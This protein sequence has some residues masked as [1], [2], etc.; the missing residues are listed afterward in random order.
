[1]SGMSKEQIRKQSEAAYGQWADQWR[2]QAKEHYKE[3]HLRME[4]FHNIGVGKACVV[5][6][7][8]QS[9]EENID[10]LREHQE[11]V[12]IMVCDKALGHLIDNGIT[13][14]YVLVCDANVSY[15]K[16]MRPWEDKL[17]DTILFINVCGNPKWTRGN[18]FK[19]TYFFVNED[20]L[21]SEIEF[22]K[23]SNCKNVIPAATNV[24]NAMCVLLTQCSNRGRNNFFGYDKYLLLGYDYCWSN[25]KNYYAFDHDGGG[26]RW[27]MRHNIVVDKAGKIVSTSNNLLFSSKW[28]HHYLALFKLLF[29]NCSDT[30]ILPCISMGKLEDHITYKYKTD[31]MPAV[32]KLIKELNNIEMLKKNLVDKITKISTDHYKEVSAT[33]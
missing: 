19:K 18:K 30:T 12:D 15:E 7:N 24:S 4:D 28:L 33:L 3:K 1:M 20:C 2:K 27:Y 5:V 10:V 8:G 9:L 6:A 14:T 23:L 29:V 22:S 32:R 13:P 11:N 17:K 26:K 25:E 31:D 16:Y 21:K